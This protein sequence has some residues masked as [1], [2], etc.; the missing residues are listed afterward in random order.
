MKCKC[1]HCEKAFAWLGW[2]TVDPAFCCLTSQTAALVAVNQAREKVSQANG[3]SMIMTLPSGT[4]IVRFMVPN[5]PVTSSG[6][7]GKYSEGIDK[8]LGT[9]LAIA[10]AGLQS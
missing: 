9:A 4:N 1:G 7:V 10:L 8:N 3:S 5:A 6:S 2:K